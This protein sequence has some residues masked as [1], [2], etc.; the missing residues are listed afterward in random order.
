M[1]GAHNTCQN[2]CILFVKNAHTP[3]H[4]RLYNS[5]ETSLPW[6]LL[7]TDLESCAS[8]VQAV[9]C[10]PLLL[11]PLL[12]RP[13]LS[14]DAV[15]SRNPSKSTL[16]HDVVA[17]VV[18]HKQHSIIC[19]GAGLIQFVHGSHSRLATE[20]THRRNVFSPFSARVSTTREAHHERDQRDSSW[21]RL[22]SNLQFAVVR[23][24][25]FEMSHWCHCDD[26]TYLDADSKPWGLL[27]HLH[28]S[29]VD[30]LHNLR[31]L[32][33]SDRLTLH[34][35]HVCVSV[36]M[37]E[38]RSVEKG[39]QRVCRVL[40]TTWPWTRKTRHP[41][42]SWSTCDRYCWFFPLP[43]ILQTCS[44]SHSTVLPF[45][46]STECLSVCASYV[47]M[48]PARELLWFCHVNNSTT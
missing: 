6:K 37:L 9:V 4:V 3:V 17:T 40:D 14:P 7:R 8:I 39:V 48:V 36:H 21:A 2:A 13:N 16:A 42:A 18:S 35:Y 26:G 30:R 34:V 44:S 15:G 43:H 10:R 31:M 29:A 19:V 25:C 45:W 1:H 24:L 47:R 32:G 12:S 46:K 28:P 23:Y 41:R 27:C 5:A 11:A 22:F 38:L 20:L 33:G